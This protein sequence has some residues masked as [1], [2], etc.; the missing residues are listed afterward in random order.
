MYISDVNLLSQVGIITGAQSGGVTKFLPQNTIIRA[1]A[2]ANYYAYD[3]NGTVE[4]MMLLRKRII[5]PAE[6]LFF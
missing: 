1:E 4:R 6:M 3:K 2:S 5:G